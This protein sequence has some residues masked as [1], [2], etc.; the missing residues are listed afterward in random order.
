MTA[1]NVYNNSLIYSKCDL[2]IISLGQNTFKRLFHD[3]MIIAIF[4]IYLIGRVA[5]C[6]AGW[7][8][9]ISQND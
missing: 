9:F 5:E 2:S 1:N 6:L 4:H 7:V 3:K 8:L